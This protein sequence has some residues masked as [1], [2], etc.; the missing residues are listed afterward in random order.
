MMQRTSYSVGFWD[1]AGRALTF[2][3]ESIG[4]AF[5]QKELLVPSLCSFLVNALVIGVF[6]LIAHYTG[7]MKVLFADRA[8]RLTEPENVKIIRYITFAGLTFLCYIITYFFMGMT[9]NLVSARLHGQRANLGVA[10]ADALNNATALVLLAVVSTLVSLITGAMR[11]RNR[12][13]LGDLAAGMIERSWTVA[14]YLLVP[15]IILEDVPFKKS[16]ERGMKL[17]GGNFVPIAVGEVA[18]STV[19]SIIIMAVVLLSAI[20]AGWAYYSGQQA[21]M[22]GLIAVGALLFILTIAFTEFV[23]TAYYTCLYLWAVE[24]EQV[25]ETARVPAPL[26]AA[27]AR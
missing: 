4:M 18:V 3:Q 15:V 6:I 24:R 10:F 22:M 8:E 1:S 11:S 12:R 2:I 14:T 20:A 23:R 16:L 5:R 17:H 13:G 26:A 21:L 25:G 7:N 19:N 9:V 27:L